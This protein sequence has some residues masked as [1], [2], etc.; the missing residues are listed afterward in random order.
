M[1]SVDVTKL[2]WQSYKLKWNEREANEK[3]A[4][5]KYYRALE[6][7]HTKWEAHKQTC[8]RTAGVSKA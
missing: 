8:G 4:E 7:E 3:D 6:A 2:V 5:L 1:R